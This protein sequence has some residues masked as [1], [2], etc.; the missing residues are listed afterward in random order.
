MLLG[1]YWC[2]FYIA[3]TYTMYAQSD[4]AQAVLKTDGLQI[5]DKTMSVAISNPPERKAP[6]GQ[7]TEVPEYTRALGG[8]KKDLGA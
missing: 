8:G 4:A 7:R 6:I 1:V 3:F 5:G 2:L